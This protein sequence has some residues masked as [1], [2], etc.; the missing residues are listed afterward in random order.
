VG[1]V[2][3]AG[4][5]TG[6][7]L[8]PGLALAEVLAARGVAVTFVGTAGGIEAR[9]VPDAGYPL[10]LVPARQ[11]R[12]GGIG[13]AAGG[14]FATG[15]AVVTA[16]R[17]LGELRPGLV[18]G[19]GGY[20]SVA[21]VVAAWLRRIPTVLLEQNVI[22]G[23]ANRVLARFARRVCVGFAET[24]PL[25]P[26]GRAVHTGNPI[27][28]EL[29]GAPAARR[30]DRVGLLLVGGS[31]GARRLN[32][33]MLEAAR[34]LGPMAARLAITH[35]TGSADLATIRAG[36]ADLGLVARVEPFFPDM[37][38]AYAAADLVVARAGAMTCAE[39]TAVGLPAILVP[40]PHAADDHQRRNA[41]VLER[42][43]AARMILESELS[44]E[45]LAAVLREFIEDPAG[46]AA[47]GARARALG[48]A[49]AAARVSE[50]CFR[51][52]R[53]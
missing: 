35:Q 26:G 34:S 8:Y 1:G 2:V 20:A 51:L 29:L 43:G 27:R 28:A 22:P 16:W 10:R 39:V 45:R 6:G 3:I 49:D 11:L 48:R 30:P 17:L 25:V 52:L 21:A 36:Y 14:L 44:G 42:A 19:V 47:M 23:A 4:G 41:E 5:G 18:V 13:R 32:Q 33:V 12:G 24:V 53:P 50:E 9:V 46:R 15:R 31:A 40:Y 7:H 38:A 37:G